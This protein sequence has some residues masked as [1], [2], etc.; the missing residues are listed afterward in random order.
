MQEKIHGAFLEDEFQAQSITS[1]TAPV[2]R[3]KKAKAE[4]HLGAEPRGL[5]AARA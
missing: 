3:S 1:T 5:W 2:S 4:Y